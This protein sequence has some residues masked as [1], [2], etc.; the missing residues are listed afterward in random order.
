MERIN[1]MIKITEHFRRNEN[2]EFDFIGYEVRKEGHAAQR[3]QRDVIK[4]NGHLQKMTI[5]IQIFTI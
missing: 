3:G 1:R 5:Q 2:C 4:P